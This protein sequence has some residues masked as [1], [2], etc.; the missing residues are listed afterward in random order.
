VPSLVVIVLLFTGESL[1]SGS[2]RGTRVVTQYDCQV[3]QSRCYLGLFSRQPFPSSGEREVSPGARYWRALPRELP[4]QIWLARRRGE[5]RGRASIE[6]G[7]GAW[8]GRR[9]SNP[10]P[11]PWEVKTSPFNFSL[12]LALE[13]NRSGLITSPLSQSVPPPP[14]P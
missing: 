1:L 5:V 4:R 10:L 2:A 3:W 11:Q 7:G 6:L 13:L 12:Q 9:D 8:S 14:E